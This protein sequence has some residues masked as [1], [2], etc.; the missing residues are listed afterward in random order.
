MLGSFLLRP[1]RSRVI[2]VQSE[3]VERCDHPQPNVLKLVE[4]QHKNGAGL[5]A[6]GAGAR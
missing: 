2:G 4:R 6:S 5:S 1:R 3:G